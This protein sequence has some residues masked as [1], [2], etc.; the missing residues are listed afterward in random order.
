MPSRRNPNWATE[1]LATEIPATE[2]TNGIAGLP[3][4]LEASPATEACSASEA[5]SPTESPV[6]MSPT[7][8]RHAALD[9]QDEGHPAEALELWRAVLLAGPASAE[10]HFLAADLLYQLGDLAAARE[11]YYMAIETDEE[12]DEARANLGCVLTELGDPR[13]AADAF[14]GALAHNSDFADAH[15][16]LAHLLE[17]LEQPVEAREHWQA[18]LHLAPESSWAEEARERLEE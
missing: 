13:L 11:R 3:E 7:E 6:E 9:L 16:H 1:I 18:Y 8:M 10:D 12:Y 14:R 2:T 15:Y 4:E 5:M 17:Q